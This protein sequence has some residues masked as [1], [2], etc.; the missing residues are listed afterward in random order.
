M[1]VEKRRERVFLNL[2]RQFGL[3]RLSEV[4]DTPNIAIIGSGGGL[5]AVI[6]MSAAMTALK[7]RGILDSTMYTAGLSRSAWYLMSLYSC[8]RPNATELNTKLRE[9]VPQIRSN[10][11]LYAWFNNACIQDMFNGLNFHHMRYSSRNM[12][13]LLT[14][15]N[16]VIHFMEDLLW[17]KAKKRQYIF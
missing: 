14:W 15:R 10:M 13:L 7:E 16:L 2:K 5:R 12:A 6:G 9:I 3:H 1:F 11:F 17:R 4:K 8:K